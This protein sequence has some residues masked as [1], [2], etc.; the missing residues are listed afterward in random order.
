MDMLQIQQLPDYQHL[1]IDIDVTPDLSEDEN[2]RADFECIAQDLIN[3]WMQPTGIADGTPEGAEW[4]LS[5]RMQLS[6][7]F[8]RDALFAL[9]IALEVQ[10]ERDDRV[11]S[12]N[13]VLTA[14]DNNFL[15]VRATV[16]VGQAAYPFSFR[17]SITTVGDLYVESLGS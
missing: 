13:V 3:M 16:N 14:T 7:G 1:G 10:A 12:C 9:K 11:D 4:G 8:T 15:I 5:L 17:A 6:R 2:L